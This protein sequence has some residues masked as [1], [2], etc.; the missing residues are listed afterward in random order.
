YSW[1]RLNV[2]GR[3]SDPAEF[4]KVIVK[5]GRAGEITRLSD[6]GR[7]ELG[8]QTYGQVF[9]LDGQ[10]AA[11]LAVYQAPGANALNVANEVRE[12]LAELKREFPQGLIAEIPF[13]SR[14]TRCTRRS[15]R[16]RSSCSSSSW[17]SCRTGARC[18]SRGRRC[19]SPSSA[20]LRRWRRSA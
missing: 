17:C 3:L 5:T 14:S 19:R 12:K 20:P 1:R 8:A 16:P 4:A 11:G 13:D 9:T 7:V 2:F 6:V 18:W 15:T 10:P